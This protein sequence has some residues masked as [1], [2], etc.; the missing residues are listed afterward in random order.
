MQ[1]ADADTGVKFP[2]LS[3]AVLYCGRLLQA[4]G[5][6]LTQHSRRTRR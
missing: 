4:L 2:R 3:V 6:D 5:F 1:N